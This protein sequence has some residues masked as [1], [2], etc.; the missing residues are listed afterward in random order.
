MDESDLFDN[1]FDDIYQRRILAR[2]QSVSVSD[3]TRSI[4]DGP[5]GSQDVPWYHLT[6]I[7]SI[8]LAILLLLL[9]LVMVFTM[10][11]RIQKRKRQEMMQRHSSKRRRRP[12][13][14]AMDKEGGVEIGLEGSTVRG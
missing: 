9:L 14:Q 4:D 8:C 11:V 6:H 2:D 3:E 12:V 5:E 13:Q 7:Q 10:L 1:V